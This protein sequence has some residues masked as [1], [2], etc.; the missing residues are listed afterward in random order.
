[1]TESHPC[2]GSF[3]DAQQQRHSRRHIQVSLFKQA[4]EI[5]RARG[6]L[7]SLLF[8]RSHESRSRRSFLPI[9][10]FPELVAWRTTDDTTERLFK[11]RVFSVTGFLGYLTVSEVFFD[12][13]SPYSLLYFAIF[14]QMKRELVLNSNHCARM[15]G[16]MLKLSILL[17]CTIDNQ[18]ILLFWCVVRACATLF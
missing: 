8:T 9:L 15:I 11:R 1:M 3:R 5:A 4:C 6:K 7:A 16:A 10:L 2:F 13:S 17:Y 12:H 18:L 14:N